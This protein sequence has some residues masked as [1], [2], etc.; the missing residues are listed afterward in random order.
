LTDGHFFPILVDKGGS[1]ALQEQP[2]R[3]RQALAKAQQQVDLRPLA[4]TFLFVIAA[5]ALYAL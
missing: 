5:F 3:R 2:M 4:V 1:L